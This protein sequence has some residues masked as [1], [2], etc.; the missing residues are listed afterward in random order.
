MS[1]LVEHAVA[2]S[3]DSL[4]KQFAA[5][6]RRT[7][8]TDRDNEKDAVDRESAHSH[9]HIKREAETG[10]LPPPSCERM[11]AGR[12]VHTLPFTLHTC[13]P[14]HRAKEWG[15]GGC[16][17]FTLHASHFTILF[18]LPH[19]DRPRDRPRAHL[20]ALRA[21]PMILYRC[22]SHRRDAPRRDA[23]RRCGPVRG[24]AR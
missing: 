2:L 5:R 1:D 18:I 24:R 20:L 7:R 8:E 12:G 19:T 16:P 4:E 22:R 13:S 14:L 21:D 3:V 15:R 10:T 9:F 6:R 11:G 23:R 17:H